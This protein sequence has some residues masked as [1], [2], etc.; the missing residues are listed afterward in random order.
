[1]SAV[2][3]IVTSARRSQPV[4]RVLLGLA[5]L[6]SGI[7][8]PRASAS[9]RHD[10]VQ[11]APNADAHASEFA[12]DDP[13]LTRMRGGW[14]A[15]QWNFSADSGVAAPQ[16]WSHLLA[17]GRP[18]G[19]G[20]IVAVLDS[21][22][23]YRDDP[24]YRLSPDFARS[25]FVRGYDFIDRD[26]RPHDTSGHGTHIAST[27]AER[28]NNGIGLTGLAYGARIMP[29]RVLDARGAGDAA[30]IARG[31]RFAT[32]RGADVINLSMEFDPRTRARDIPSLI[33][34]LNYARRRGVVV[35]AAAGNEARSRV[36]YPARHW[37]TI[38]VGATT[39]SR[40]GAEYSNYGPRIDLVA[41]G[42]GDDA[43]V[44]GDPNC[45]P[46]IHRRPD[47]LQIS[48]DGNPRRFGPRGRDGT[49]MSAP[50]VAAAA[51]LVIAGGLLGRDPTPAAV[52]RHLKATAHDLG[53]PGK[54][55]SYGAGLLD[56]AAATAPR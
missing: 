8:P 35:V 26:R 27:I 41:P 39:I 54:D 2:R 25:Q 42:G 12:P 33:D 47:I 19:R 4:A 36:P 34:A 18:G 24:P 28:T 50:H 29:I 38:A 1:V 3:R 45:D 40:C 10:V 6:A 16:A 43:D 48:F 46:S 14:R 31:V 22:V 51:A 44:P 9:T 17:A 5:C 20:T 53:E 21:G 30:D 49:S 56:A 7:L 32:R 52:K 13:G 11:A 15:A 23:A 55:F 37:T